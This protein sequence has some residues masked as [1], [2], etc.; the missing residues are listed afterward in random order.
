MKVKQVLL[1]IGVVGCVLL[2]WPGYRFVQLQNLSKHPA[3]SF[4]EVTGKKL[5]ADIQVLA[6]SWRVKDLFFN[7]SHAWRFSGDAF[8][9]RRLATD[10]SLTLSADAV[11]Q[12][13]EAVQLSGL[14]MTSQNAIRGFENVEGSSWYWICAGETEALFK[15]H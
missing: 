2:S 10:M 15:Y 9:L 8:A 7:V 14:Q 13:P 5:P 6:H 12:Y 3:E 4:V 1:V 11:T